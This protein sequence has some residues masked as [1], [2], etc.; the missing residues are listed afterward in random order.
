M[1]TLTRSQ[2]AIMLMMRRGINLKHLASANSWIDTEYF[3]AHMNFDCATLLEKGYLQ[4]RSRIYRDTIY[5]LSKIGKEEASR[6]QRITLA[7]TET[8]SNLL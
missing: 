5:E 2:I 7:Q 4:V 3:D 1:E 8:I 6:Q